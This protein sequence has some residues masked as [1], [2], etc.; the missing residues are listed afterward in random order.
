MTAR[1]GSADKDFRINQ[2]PISLVRYL[3]DQLRWLIQPALART[4][5]IVHQL[6]RTAATRTVLGVRRHINWDNQQPDLGEALVHLFHDIRR[7]TCGI[8]SAGSPWFSV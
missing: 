8:A 2:I 7:R 4:V 1:F 5:R 3:P 6:D